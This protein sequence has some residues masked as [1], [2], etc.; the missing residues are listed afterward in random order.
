M[1]SVIQHA[2]LISKQVIRLLESLLQ[3]VVS[4][5]QYKRIL[6]IA[7]ENLQC[8]QFHYGE[9]KDELDNF[10]NAIGQFAQIRPE[11]SCYLIEVQVEAL[12]KNLQ[13]L[14]LNTPQTI[15]TIEEYFEKMIGTLQIVKEM[16]ESKKLDIRSKGY[17]VLDVVWTFICDGND[18]LLR[19]YMQ[20]VFQIMDIMCESLSLMHQLVSTESLVV[21]IFS[22]CFT[23]KRKPIIFRFMEHVFPR[24][25][26]D[27]DEDEVEVEL[28]KRFFHCLTLYASSLKNCF[29]KS[30][31]AEVKF[32]CKVLSFISR[33]YLSIIEGRDL[34]NFEQFFE[35]K[36]NCY[37]DDCT[38]TSTVIFFAP[39]DSHAYYYSL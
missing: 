18:T 1:S 6:R 15:F 16:I 14:E 24:L 5:E 8:K 36:S 26:L 27:L 34:S 9:S 13:E 4:S 12:S 23:E 19:S 37:V 38:L 32:A 3:T 35:M 21:K 10:I 39:L 17:E 7:I 33:I 28:R 2:P 30:D 20:Y 11:Y 25:E 22:S 29:D 31:P